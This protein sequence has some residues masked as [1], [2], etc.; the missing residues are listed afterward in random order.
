MSTGIPRFTAA[1]WE[2][3]RKRSG[4]TRVTVGEQPSATDAAGDKP[5]GRDLMIAKMKGVETAD[6]SDDAYGDFM[7]RMK[8]IKR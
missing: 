2:S 4:D 7:L 1:E 5:I 8:G 3:F 6:D